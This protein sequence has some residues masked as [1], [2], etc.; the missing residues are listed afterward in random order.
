MSQPGLFISFEGIDGAG[1]SSH[2]EGLASAFRA[3]GRRVTVSR[4]PG[5]TPLAEKLRALLLTER[6]DALTASLLIFAARPAAARAHGRP[7]RTAA[8]LRRPPRPPVPGHRTRAG[9]RRRGAVRPVYRLDLCLPGC[10][11]RVRPR[12]ASHTRAHDEYGS[13]ARGWFAA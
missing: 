6:M 2:V 8:D 11:T 10:R 1:K 13:S 3:Q 4:E 7:H 9:A 12:N 5:G